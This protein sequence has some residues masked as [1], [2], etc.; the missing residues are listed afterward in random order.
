MRFWWLRMRESWISSLDFPL[1]A[2][3]IS[4]LLLH[5]EG[6]SFRIRLLLAE[7]LS[8]RPEISLRQNLG[9]TLGSL[10]WP[11]FYILILSF[12]SSRLRAKLPA[13]CDC[14][15]TFRG[16]SKGQ[17]GSSNIA[18]FRSV[19]GAGLWLSCRLVTS[20]RVALRTVR[21]GDRFFVIWFFGDLTD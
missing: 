11:I 13:E 1:E 2:S 19:S 21:L 20:L 17:L 10:L 18:S 8:W 12:V 7:G 9:I 5:S 15:F 3:A 6:Y 14:S 4:Y 16:C